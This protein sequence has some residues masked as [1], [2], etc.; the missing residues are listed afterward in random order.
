MYLTILQ[1]VLLL[2]QDVDGERMEIYHTNV[3]MCIKSKYVIVCL[4]TVD[5]KEE[6]KWLRIH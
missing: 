2:N 6:R 4:D 3:M 5:D 1:F